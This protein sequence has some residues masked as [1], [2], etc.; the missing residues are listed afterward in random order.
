MKA[1]AL[2]REQHRRVERLLV[3]IG[4]EPEVRL[5]LVLQLVQELM[6]HLSIED[7]IF[8]DPLADWTGLAPDAC[9]EGQAR[10][11]NAVLQAVFAEDN[12]A[13]FADRIRE[14]SAVFAQHVYALEHDV[15]PMADARL[16][17]DDLESMGARMERSWNAAIRGDRPSRPA[18]HEHAAE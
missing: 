15:F 4:G 1:T 18:A 5:A 12:D 13:L 3:R 8:L 2:L 10:V 9:R 11:R 6:T 14:L 16:R 7:H 17:S